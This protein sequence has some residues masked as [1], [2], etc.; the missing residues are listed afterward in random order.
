MIA[1]PT[2]M[3]IIKIMA[4][5]AFRAPSVYE[6][7]YSDGGASQVQSNCCSSTGLQPETVYSAEV[8]YTHKLDRDWSILGSIYDTYASNIVESVPVP[9][10]VI[11]MHNMGTPAYTWVDGVEYYANSSTP[12]NLAGVDLELRKEWRSGTMFLASYGYLLARYTDDTLGDTRAPNAPTHYVSMR[13]VTPLVQNLLNGAVRITYE[14]ER[15]SSTA[16]SN[17]SPRAVI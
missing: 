11:D 4:G 16:D 8:E 13:G 12:I 2:S 3:D 1:K 10:S 6:Y 7:Y 9:Q 17:V 5:R 14:D 15:R